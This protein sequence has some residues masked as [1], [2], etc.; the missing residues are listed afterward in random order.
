MRPSRRGG[1]ILSHRGGVR[2]RLA[3][4]LL[5]VLWVCLTPA[6]SEERLAFIG[7]ALDVETR[8]ADRILQ[9]Y[10]Y[11]TAGVAFAPEELEYARVI[12]RLSTWKPGDGHYLARTTPYVYVVA[13][14]LGADFEIVATYTSATTARTTYNSYFVVSRDHFETEPDLQELIRFLEEKLAPASQ[15]PSPIG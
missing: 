11:R 7:V 12:D 6:V 8:Q 2:A 1:T 3:G 5:L 10:L 9:D 14:M 13:E 4:L 15:L